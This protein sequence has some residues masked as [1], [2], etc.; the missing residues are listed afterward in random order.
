MAMPDITGAC[1]AAPLRRKIVHCLA[2]NHHSVHCGVQCR[3]AERQS[4]ATTR[5]VVSTGVP[6]RDHDVSWLLGALF[7]NLSHDAV[8]QPSPKEG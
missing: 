7:E 1:A 2:V 8:A 4:K 5:S 3:A 6:C